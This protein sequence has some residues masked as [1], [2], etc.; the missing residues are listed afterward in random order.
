MQNL[1][2]PSYPLLHRQTYEPSV[3]VHIAFTSQSLE[4]SDSHS[5]ISKIEMITLSFLLLFDIKKKANS[6]ACYKKKGVEN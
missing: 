2:S 4:S 3:F 5:S 6:D 1:P